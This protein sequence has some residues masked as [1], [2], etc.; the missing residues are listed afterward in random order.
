MTPIP[1][2][3]TKA[4][5]KIKASSIESDEKPQTLKELLNEVSSM[6]V[7]EREK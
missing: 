5:N 6:R 4:R 1:D 7:V 2:Q 3:N